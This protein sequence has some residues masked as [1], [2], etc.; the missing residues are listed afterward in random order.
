MFDFNKIKSPIIF[1]G[2][3]KTAYRDP[4]VYY[5]NGKFYLFC[6]YV[7][8]CEDGP[9]LTVVE[10][11][12]DDLVSWTAPR[13]ITPRDRALNYSSPGNII[14]YNGEYILCLQTYCRENG[15]KY[16]NENCRL[17]TMK[18]RD[19]LSWDEP[20]I[21][22]VK[23]DIPT[24]NMG[25]MIDPFLVQDINEPG[26]WWCLYKQNGVSMSY[27]YD[28]ENWTFHS[29]T[30]SGE[31]VCVLAKDG[32]YLILHSPKNGIGVMKTDDFKS[33]E[34]SPELITLGQDLWDWAKGRI[35][36]GFLLDLTENAEYGKYLLFFHG[37]GP[38]D[39][40]TMFDHHASIGLA[41]SDDLVSW[42]WSK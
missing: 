16:G 10:S 30:E 3:D 6:T 42:E 8:C 27:S 35:T 31:N 17:F 18:S 14:K 33:F 29:K 20:R 21:I 34:K 13:E 37:S 22:K 12:S 2:S 39:E 1:E 28:L 15:E 5:E 23:G 36:A 7:E 38:E 4:A 24:E 32:Q 41:W 9:Y 11:V 26:K 25:R 19:L 40:E